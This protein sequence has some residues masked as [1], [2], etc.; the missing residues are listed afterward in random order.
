MTIKRAKK[1]KMPEDNRLVKER[2]YAE[3][4]AKFSVINE[5]GVQVLDEDAFYE[6][7]TS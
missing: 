3:E 6:V 5:Q 1:D 2:L 7:W 4:L